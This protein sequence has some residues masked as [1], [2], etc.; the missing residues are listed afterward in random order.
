[1][2]TAA[3]SETINLRKITFTLKADADR[4][5]EAMGRE[6]RLCYKCNVYVDAQAH[7][8]QIT[9]ECLAWKED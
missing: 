1:M 2:K 7:F 4:Y 5:A 3:K 8:S 6:T 9:G